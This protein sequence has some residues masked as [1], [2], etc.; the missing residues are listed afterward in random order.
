ML[1][2]HKIGD[3]IKVSEF[4]KRVKQFG[5]GN[6][7]TTAHTFFRLSQRQRKIYTEDSLKEIVFNE[8]PLE[9]GVEKNGNCAVIYNFDKGEALLKIIISLGS[10]KIY[11]VTFY[12][13]NKKQK[14]NF[15]NGKISK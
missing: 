14:E 1:D 12:I 7:E 13:L 15:E 2:E 9:I 4:I 10:N 3:K 11:I 8:T 6:I 5:I